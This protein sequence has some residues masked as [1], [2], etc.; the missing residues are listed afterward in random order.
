M[1]LYGVKEYLVFPPDQSRY[2]YP[3]AEMANVT[4]IPDIENVDLSQF[5]LFAQAEGSRFEL[6]PGETLF[7]PAGWWHTARILTTAITVSI[8]G[9]SAGNC[10]DFRRDYCAQVACY[11]RLKA[12]LM[13]PYLSA[14]GVFLSFLD[15]L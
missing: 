14:L 11:S 15:T 2:F 5:P 10:R 7:V 1:Q 3:R 12:T 13:A 9:V 4:S 6:H 8:N